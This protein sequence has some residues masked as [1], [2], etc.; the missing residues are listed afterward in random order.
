MMGK[1]FWEMIERSWEHHGNH[2]QIIL[3]S[4]KSQIK[5]CQN[6]ETC[7]HYCPFLLEEL[8]SQMFK[9]KMFTNINSKNHNVKLD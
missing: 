4:C 6:Y 5:I 8:V 9:Q 1:W 2:E 3:K 7:K